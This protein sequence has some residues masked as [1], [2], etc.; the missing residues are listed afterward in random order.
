MTFAV[1]PGNATGGHHDNT[2]TATGLDDEGGTATNT[3]TATVT[4]TNVAPA[5]KVVKTVSPESVPETG[6]AVTCAFVVTNTSP[7]GA[8]DP[9]HGVTLTDTDAGTI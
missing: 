1:P 9:L 4:Y 7:A 5:I 2:A 6:G 8:F 3:A